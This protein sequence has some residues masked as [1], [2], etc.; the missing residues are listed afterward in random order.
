MSFFF[1]EQKNNNNTIARI[2]QLSEAII[3]GNDA[4]TV[5]QLLKAVSSQCARGK[6]CENW[7]SIPIFL[8]GKKLLKM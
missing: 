7:K 5:K 4:E 3:T 1:R 8:S 2:Q 6:S